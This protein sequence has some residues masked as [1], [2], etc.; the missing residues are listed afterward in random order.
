MLQGEKSKGKVEKLFFVLDTI[1][2]H[3]TALY[4]PHCALLALLNG[5][6][7]L[8]LDLSQH[9]AHLECVASEEAKE[10]LRTIELMEKTMSSNLMGS[11]EVTFPQV[12]LSWRPECLLL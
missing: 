3:G 2:F 7:L 6:E 5:D 9:W 4:S 12:I 1:G 10:G 8:G 11:L